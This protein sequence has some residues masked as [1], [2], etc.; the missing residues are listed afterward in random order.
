[1]PP[2]QRQVGL[3]A[4][5]SAFNEQLR[6]FRRRAG[7]SQE[8]LAERAGLAASAVG[9]LEQG[10][11]RRPYPR[12]VAVLA[13]ALGLSPDEH[14]ALMRALRTSS[15]AH[16][17][18]AHVTQ[19][20]S[21]RS[22]LPNSR[23]SLIGRAPELA[24]VCE[25]L[26]SATTRLVSVTGGG[27]AGKTRLALQA[28]TDLSSDFTDG[29]WLV[30]LAPLADPALVARVVASILGARETPGQSPLENVVAFLQRKTLLL[31]LDNCEHL[32]S[33]CAELAEG[34]LAGCPRVRLLATSREPLLINGERQVRLASLAAP[35]A[36]DQLSTGELA[37]YPAV[38]LFVE[39]AQAVVPGF[40]LTSETAPAV[41]QVCARLDGIPLALELAAARLRALALE[42][43][44]ERL[45]DAFHLLVG[46]SRTAPARQQALQATLDWSYALLTEPERALFRR[47]AVFAGG[48]RLEAAEHV[49][50]PGVTSAT[51]DLLTSLVDKS[52]VVVH[53][54]EL[55][56][57]Y[58]L[59]EPV[60]Q[61]AEQLLL[62][63]GENELVRQR[64][65]QY[66]V[67]LAECAASE[68]A[69]PAQTVWLVWLDHELDN[70]R[71][72]LHWANACQDENTLLR[73]G[74]ALVP[75]WE[76]RGYVGE[77]RG[78][79]E[80]VLERSDQR[81]ESRLRVPAV[82]GIAR[83]ALFQPDLVTAVA[84]FAQSRTLATE[85]GDRRLLAEAVTGLGV[86]HRRQGAMDVAQRLL[87]EGLSQHEAA[88][89]A[90]GAAWAL[91]NLGH[92]ALNERDWA[93]ASQVLDICLQ[94]YR[95]LGNVR[96]IGLTCVEVAGA[97][98]QLGQVE[99][100]AS[101]LGEGLTT[102]Q[103]VGDR[104]FAAPCLVVVAWSAAVVG[105]PVRAARLLGAADALRESLGVPI[106][107]ANQLGEIGALEVIGRQLDQPQ[108]DAARAAGRHL[109]LHQ[110]FAEA[111]TVVAC[112]WAADQAASAAGVEPR[113]EALTAR[114]QEVV[115]LVIQ[116]RT[117]RQI[118][119]ALGTATS[120]ASVH[121]KHLLAKLDLHSRWQ[122]R[123][124][125]LANGW[126]E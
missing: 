114:E 61:Y 97:V 121:V 60:R 115:R 27:G 26:A 33:A 69:G 117:D 53:H 124:W 125:A 40:H 81:T 103:A 52:L 15:D 20:D 120:T 14:A 10:L 85:L 37:R 16:A 28:A 86:A 77:G 96:L 6:W 62:A 17:V 19:A 82:L 71:G 68:L 109:T 67:D 63:C 55:T 49:S 100:A 50:A 74:V 75:F 4:E 23:T 105:Q 31:V 108:L 56:A 107:P 89:D 45:G 46:G 112:M 65:A 122:I 34:I 83:L 95:A 104:A 8:Q 38:Q 59:L 18:A 118:A 79:L 43:L 44:V 110:A 90:P 116:G 51:V 94:R 93:R 91:F 87:E 48:F 29:V 2:S 3:L 123:D 73:L 12:T 113:G 9:A 64:H 5:R 30:E 70:L 102:L 39:R 21:P 25:L 84:R 111:E 41:T 99:R 47:L 101:L 54:G 119:A 35:D 66:Y 92:I 7:L 88:G 22:N 106:A 126:A 76:V 11:R 58:R 78:W 42:Q 1:M 24:H 32:V 80:G 36:G 98:V 72:A 13:Q 57:W